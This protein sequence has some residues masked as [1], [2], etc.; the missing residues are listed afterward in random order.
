MMR[1]WTGDGMAFTKDMH[2]SASVGV[3]QLSTWHDGHG[4]P[5]VVYALRMLDLHNNDE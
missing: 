2:L 5:F 1:T 3:S 4:V